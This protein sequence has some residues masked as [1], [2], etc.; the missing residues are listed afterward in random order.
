MGN[1]H[2]YFIENTEIL[3]NK[4]GITN[5]DELSKRESEIVVSKLSYLYINGMNGDFSINHLCQIHKFLF[6]DLYEFAGEFRDVDMRK[7]TIFVPHQEIK[8]RLEELFSKMDNFNFNEGNKFEIAKY[9]AEFYYGII[10][11]HPFR[12]GN[13]RTSRE[14]IRQLV[15]AKFP[16]YELDYTK[17]NK[18]NFQIGV[19]DYRH[20][21]LLLAYEIYNALGEVENVKDATR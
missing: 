18:E 1:W 17:I 2:D 4:L 20:Y 11:I 13:G 10:E 7:I 21:P 6:G 5:Q 8:E 19:I 9:V 16:K 12:E 14:F 3:K 15:L